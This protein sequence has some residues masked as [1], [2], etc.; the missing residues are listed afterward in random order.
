MNQ[1]NKQ[2]EETMCIV[3]A[4]WFSCDEV[5]IQ[6]KQACPIKE[7]YSSLVDPLLLK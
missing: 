3:G 1:I 6:F 4:K 5:L 7:K 2:K